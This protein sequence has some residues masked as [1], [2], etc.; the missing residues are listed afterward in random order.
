MYGRPQH[1]TKY[2]SKNYLHNF[3][4]IKMSTNDLIYT[5]HFT[6]LKLL[7]YSNVFEMSKCFFIFAV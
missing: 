7:N 5:K 2:L 4:S 1:L 6:Q 3:K